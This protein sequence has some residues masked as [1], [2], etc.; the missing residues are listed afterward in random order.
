MHERCASFSVYLAA[1]HFSMEW[2]ESF[3]TGITRLQK[4]DIDV[5]ILHLRSTNK[6]TV[7]TIQQIRDAKPTIPVVVLSEVA[8]EELAVK[9]VKVGAQDYLVKGEFDL[10]LIERTLR[11]AVERQQ[12]QNALA[13]QQAK[14]DDSEIKIREQTQVLQSIL[15]GLSDGVVVANKE[16]K[17]LLF[18]PAAER[19]VG[20]GEADVKPD[21]WSQ[22]LSVVSCGQNHPFS[23]RKSTFGP[24]HAR[25]KLCGRGSNR[26]SSRWQN[27]NA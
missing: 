9:A 24:S 22:A 14:L 4:D 20:K 26:S 27:D 23:T 7:S 8:D 1:I 15:H 12:T 16:G 25:R 11:Y 3:A 5:V 21:N 13:V 18:N 17:F 10:S 19:M 2:A 6:E